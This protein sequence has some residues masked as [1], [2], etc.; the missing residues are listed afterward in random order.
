MDSVT[1]SPRVVRIPTPP[2]APVSRR[3]AAIRTGRIATH[4]ETRRRHIVAPRAPYVGYSPA[5]AN[6]VLARIRAGFV[7]TTTVA[8]DGYPC[9]GTI[10]R[11]Y[12]DDVDGFAA[13]YREA[14]EDRLLLWAEEI[15]E[16]ADDTSQ[17]YFKELDENGNEKRV[18]N[19]TAI[20]RAQLRIQSRQWMLSRLLSDRFGDKPAHIAINSG[21]T[22]HN[23]SFFPTLI[24][25]PVVRLNAP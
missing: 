5:V 4:A 14:Q 25:N 24:I 17:D 7:L 22:Q 9:L 10:M 23:N 13:K 6:K 2:P 16:I 19:L 8:D 12:R 1:F 11:W 20:R 15:V 21:N 3:E 18:F